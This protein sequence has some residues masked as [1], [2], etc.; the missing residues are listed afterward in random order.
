V[1]R[2]APTLSVLSA[3]TIRLDWRFPIFSN[4]GTLLQ[5]HYYNLTDAVDIG[6]RQNHT[7]SQF[8]FNRIRGTLVMCALK[9]CREI[10]Y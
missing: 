1:K 3:V 10:R 9:D 4:D 7:S 6:A 5:F 8:N 2:D